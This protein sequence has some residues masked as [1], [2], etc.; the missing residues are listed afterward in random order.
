MG[1]ISSYPSERQFPKDIRPG[2]L[3]V[4]KNHNTILVPIN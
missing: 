2:Q 1:D 3:Y 4:D